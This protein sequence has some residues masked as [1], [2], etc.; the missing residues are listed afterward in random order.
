MLKDSLAGFIWDSG[1]SV[2]VLGSKPAELLPIARVLFELDAQSPSDVFVLLTEPATALPSYVD[3]LVRAVGTYVAEANALDEA[4]T[5]RLAPVPAECHE[6]GLAPIERWKR[7]LQYLAGLIPGEGEHRLVVA[8]LPTTI[9]DAS[10]YAQVAGQLFIAPEADAWR[11]K[12]KAVVF[13]DSTRPLL[14]PAVRATPRSH[15]LVYTPDLG[16]AAA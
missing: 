4:D 8:L 16:P 6:A 12:L 14:V 9:V 1:E 10:G 7:L 11:Q 5:E 3:A 2:L 13:D 15:C